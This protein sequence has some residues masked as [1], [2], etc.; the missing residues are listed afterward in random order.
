M[1]PEALFCP[2]DIGV[3]QA[4][5]A[6]TVANALVACHPVLRPLLAQ[7]VLLCGGTAMCPGFKARLERDLRP[8]VDTH[9]DLAVNQ[10]PDAQGMAWQ[11][12]SVF[13]ASPQFRHV[14]VTRAQYQEHGAHRLTEMMS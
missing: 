3:S 10:G 1:V 14:A 7:N 13:A 6:E 12:A 5:A 8:L 2:S 9:Y 11:G 4:G